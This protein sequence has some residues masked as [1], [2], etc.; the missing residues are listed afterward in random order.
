MNMLKGTIGKYLKNKESE[1]EE[2]FRANEELLCVI[3]ED[4][5]FKKIN[6]AW[7]EILGYTEKE[8]ISKNLK[9]FVHHEDLSKTLK[10]HEKLKEKGKIS[11]FVNRFKTKDGNY[12]YLSWNAKGGKS[13]LY[14]YIAKVLIV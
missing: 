7:T 5:N 13:G 10:E 4:G 8:V 11:G 9:K 14:Y 6:T 12:I 3:T 2:F 1:A